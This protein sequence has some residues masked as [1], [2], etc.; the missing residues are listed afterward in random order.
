MTGITKGF[1]IAGCAALLLTAGAGVANAAPEGNAYGK[2]AKDC[3]ASLGIDS[4]GA[5]I[6]AG[7]VT[8]PGAKMTAKTIAM[9]VHCTG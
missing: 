5:G 2:N 7:R 9:S 3:V 1:A 6:Q 4:L 8:H